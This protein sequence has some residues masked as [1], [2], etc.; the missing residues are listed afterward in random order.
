[1]N[2]APDPS[3]AAAASAARELAELQG[4]V[5][6]ARADLNRLLQD[7]AAA[8]GRMSKSQAALLLEANEEL[9]LA[10]LHA[11]AIAETAAQ[12]L[13]NVSQSAAL[14]AMTQLPNRLLLLDRFDHA[15]ANARRHGT[16]LALLF[17][18]LDNF[19]QIN[20]TLGHTVGDEVLKVVA[21]RVA[22]SI[23]AADTVSRHGGDEF[24]ILLT[25]VFHPFDA[26]LIASKVI[27]AIG[28]PGCLPDEALGV[29][30]SVGISVFPEDGEDGD[31]LI[32]RADA[33]MYCAKRHGPGSFA[34]H[35]QAPFGVP[36]HEPQASPGATSQPPLAHHERALAELERRNAQLREANEQL[37][38][39]ALGAQERLDAAQQA[40]RG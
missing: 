20:D 25:E 1:V 26:G 13:S 14:D 10:A 35:G 33:A 17:L 27:A 2:R 23:R 32:Q 39:A 30:A 8:E 21:Q 5:D 36:G 37:V 19:K 6:E 38:L 9:V 3:E 24:L 7:L 11:Q 40:R 29:T 22:S 18:D 34:F 31:T 28:A 15:I 12:E 16:R 4:K